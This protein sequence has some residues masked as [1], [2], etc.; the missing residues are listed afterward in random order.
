MNRIIL[1]AGEEVSAPF[2]VT[3]QVTVVARGLEPGDEVTLWLVL[4]TEPVRDPCACPPGQVVLP[5]V[6]DEVPHECC[7]EPV[8]LTRERSW[9]IIDSPQQTPIRVKWNLAGAPSTQSVYLSDTNTANVNDRMRGC[10]C[11]TIGAP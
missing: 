9:A 8:V 7:G 1:R 6:L 10:P 5:A 11:A 2:V 4:M 3:S